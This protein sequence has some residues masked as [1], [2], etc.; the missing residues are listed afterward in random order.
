[1]NFDYGVNLKV[2]YSY[3]GK[4]KKEKYVHVLGVCVGDVLREIIP[5][6]P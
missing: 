3:V 4:I 1:M 2:C 5:H 6:L